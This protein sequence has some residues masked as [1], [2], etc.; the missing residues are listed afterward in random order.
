ME[1][2]LKIE[3]HHLRKKIEKE[4]TS[5]VNRDFQQVSGQEQTNTHD[6]LLQKERELEQISG[7]LDDRVHF[8]QKP[9]E[10]PGSGSGR[11]SAIFERPP[12]HSGSYEDSRNTEFMQRPRSRGTGDRSGS[13]EDSRN[14][15]YM[16]RPRS[17]GTGDALPGQRDE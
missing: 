17:R 12:S 1:V 14:T 8:V 7:G 5:H 11:G 16:Q 13:F 4:S 15:E 2:N 3:I 10:R 6:R 9:I